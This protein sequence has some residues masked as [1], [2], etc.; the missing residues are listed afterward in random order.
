MIVDPVPIRIATL[1]TAWLFAHAVWHKL[2]RF[3]DFRATLASYQLLP[4]ALARPAAV[5]LVTLEVL[6][7]IGAALGAGPALI[8]AAGLLALYAVAMAVNLVRD[9]ALRDCGCGGPPQ[10][11]SW[12]L[13]A[14]NVL[15]GAVALVGLAPSS[16]RPLG[17]VDAFAIGT[18]L[19]LLAAAY[20]WGNALHAARAA[21]EEWV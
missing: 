14:R 19:L 12:W 10:P 3:D 18:V 13:V 5:L 17:A 8:G 11:L 21:L 9:R 20:A 16:G 1:A 6:V 4:G 2:R 15:L 7:A